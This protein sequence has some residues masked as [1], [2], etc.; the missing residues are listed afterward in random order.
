MKIH[1]YKSDISEKERLLPLYVATI[2]GIP[3]KT[4]I[5][6][7]AGIK[8][9]QL[10]YT[11]SGIGVVEIS[12]KK[13]EVHKGDMFILP[14]FTPHEYAPLT[15]TWD[16]RWITYNGTVAKGSFH[17]CADIKKMTS[18]EVFYQ[19]IVRNTNHPNWR[20][21]TSSLLY[22]LLMCI[23]ESEGISS[24]NVTSNNPDMGTAVQYISEH[25]HETVEISKLA[26]MTGLSVGHFCRV[27]KQYTHMSPIEYI[28]HLRIERAKDLLIQNPPIPIAQIAKS[29][30]YTS[31]S[32]FTK[33][34][35]TKTGL[36]PKKYRQ[37]QN[38]T[39]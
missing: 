7:P 26:D 14:P 20:R 4:K 2:G 35:K 8:D 33:T 5:H 32:Y 39:N 12:G 13:F 37:L 9:Y 29:V 24:S 22:E 23:L 34:F 15:N 16:I 18:F 30:S 17:F 31:A 3:S 27:F 11:K 25:Y 19:K 1:S 21:K 10:L 38:L 28:T 36:T 6:R